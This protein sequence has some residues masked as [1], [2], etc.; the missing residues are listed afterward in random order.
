MRSG[1]LQQPLGSL[2]REVAELLTQLQL[3]IVF[4]ES[5]TAGLIS[6]TLAR[7]P[8]ASN[9]HCG[10]AVVYRLDTKTQ[11]LDVPA[12]MLNHHGAVSDPVAATMA[13]GALFHT[14][15]ADLAVSITGH[16]G[17]HAPEEQDGLVFVGVAMR[18]R[19]CRVVEHR[20]PKIDVVNDRLRFP[21]ETEREQRQWIAVERVLSSDCRNH[22]GWRLQSLVR[23][24]HW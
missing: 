18:G 16:L 19:F 11:W 8:G 3:K 24:R 17:P 2:A 10:S 12:S 1:I 13:E 6:A 9:F 7:V 5:C 21:G 20:L 22:P 14:T 15:E 4:A 23:F